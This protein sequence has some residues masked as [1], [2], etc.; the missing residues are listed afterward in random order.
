MASSR[1][2]AVLQSG[3]KACAGPIYF[4]LAP[5]FGCTIRLCS[6]LHEGG[7]YALARRLLVMASTQISDTTDSEPLKVLH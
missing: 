1:A 3:I 2:N 7:A 6:L 5:R 4:V